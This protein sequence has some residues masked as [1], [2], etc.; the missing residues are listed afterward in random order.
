MARPKDILL[1][2][3]MDVKS[4]NG[5]F[6]IEDST[7]QNQQLL[8]VSEKGEWK[9]NPVVGIGIR[10]WLLDDATVHELHQEIQKQF[11][12]DGMRV[13]KITGNTYFDTVI[14]ADYE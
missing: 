3:N 6:V 14:D 4:K 9:E 8:L 7:L 2:D 13:N 10:S 1:D 11:S 12:L 5:D